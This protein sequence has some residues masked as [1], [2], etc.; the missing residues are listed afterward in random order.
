LEPRSPKGPERIRVVLADDH[1]ILR[2]GLR[3]LLEAEGIQVAGEASDGEE[4]LAAVARTSPDVVILDITMPRLSGLEACPRLKEISPGVKVLVLTMHEDEGYLQRL[5]RAGADGFVL[6]RSAH[7]QLVEAVRA[8][9]RGE[10][11]VDP[12]VAAL[13]VTSY[14]SPRKARGGPEEAL[15]ARELEVLKLVAR[16][17]TNRQIAERLFLSVKTVETYRARAMEKLGLATRA[18]VVR[19][20]L[21]RGLLEEG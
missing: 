6:K 1:A 10:V 12:A 2:A 5:L 11:Y 7:T 9:A 3:M 4:A 13:F 21:E 20:A 19:Y 17:Y 8:V 15:S 16:G 18:E 14:L